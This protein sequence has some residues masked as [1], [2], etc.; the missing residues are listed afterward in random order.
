ML[1]L[2]WANY[3]F[4]T[5]FVLVRMFKLIIVAVSA[6]GKVDRRFLA[7]GVG[8]IGPLELDP[9]P[10]IHTRDLV[11]HEAHRHPYIEILGLM[12]LMKLR[13]ADSFGNRAGSAWRLIFV[14][15]LMPWF[16]KYR[17]RVSDDGTGDGEVSAAKGMGEESSTTGKVRKSSLVSLATELSINAPDLGH[18]G[19]QLVTDH[20]N[21]SENEQDQSMRVMEAENVRLKEMVQQL[22]L[23]LERKTKR[24]SKSLSTRDS[25]TFQE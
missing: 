14:Y 17:I 10:T 1:A 12:Y 4:T 18:V 16:H 15:A 19:V 7:P 2:E 23:Q 11:A 5:A 6:I 13:Y 3:V 21:S 9:Y 20:S 25:Q 24:S 8:E 22:S